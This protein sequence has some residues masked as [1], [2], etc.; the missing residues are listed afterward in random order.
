MSHQSAVVAARPAPDEVRGG[1]AGARSAP[2]LGSTADS[3]STAGQGVVPAEDREVSRRARRAEAIAWRDR[4]WAFTSLSRLRQCGRVSH[5]G[6]G[7]AVLR[8][9][10]SE[11]GRRGGLAGLQSCGSPWCCPV[12]ARKI[13]AQRS[14][15]LR[16]VLEAVSVAQGSAALVTFTMRH[17]AGQRLPELWAAL[18]GAWGAVTSGRGWAAEQQ[19][20]GVLGWVRTVE[21][22]HGSAGWHLHVHA[23]LVLDGPVSTELVA[24]LGTRMFRR[25][26]RALGRHGL[27][28]VQ[29]RGGLDVRMVDM[30][31]GSL[32]RTAD[33]LA[34]ITAEITS[35]GTKDG[36]RDGNR[37]PFA[38][39][40]DA[41]ATGL[42][43][44]VELWWAWEQGSH[45]RKQLTW[46][47]A[48]RDWAGLHVERSD[49]DIVAED[50]HG[51]DVLLIPAVSWPRVR[52]ELADL[53]DTVETGGPAAAQ[54][55]MCSRGLA[56]T[57]VE[58]AARHG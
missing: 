20:Y 44:D 38:I 36:R 35:P 2:L 21:A 49:E 25:W 47:Q 51:E 46:S 24:E 56:F 15:E 6:V 29:D 16:R 23:L 52:A 33:Y 17:H 4:L 53:L 55:W 54:R 57:A 27:S 7:G 18:S 9:T 41:L 48:L 40:R 32:D 14:G 8:V 19:R 3:S 50:L 43:D 42:A 13:G 30:D 12:C 39:L 11:Q 5:T 22:T 45:N 10:E 1:G 31:G 28:A 34:K 37:S 58:P 26:D